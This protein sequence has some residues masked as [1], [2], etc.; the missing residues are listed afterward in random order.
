VSQQP[1]RVGYGEHASQ[2]CEVFG[3]EE[4]RRAAL[5]HGGFWRQKYSC[6]LEHRV[7]RDL[8]GRG[9]QVWNV[10]Y[11]RV[12]GG[13]GWPGTFDDIRTA[14]ELARADVAIGHSAGGHLAVWA[15]AEGLAPRAVAQAGVVDL[16]RA[17]ALGLSDHAVHELLGGAPEEHP[18]RYAQADPARRLPIDAKLLLVHGARDEEVPVE[19]S[20]DFAERSGCDYVEIA[21]EDHY[22][23]LDP[24]SKQWQAVL[25]WL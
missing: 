13:G 21:D 2:F 25:G 24:A 5:I 20:R 15:A 11:R 18:D 4:A 3:G 8:A 9:W 17:C 16:A 7:A 6:E 1:E 10:E 23:H 19:I 14:L 12:N 22:G